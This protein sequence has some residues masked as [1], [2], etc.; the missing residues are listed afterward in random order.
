MEGKLGSIRY[1]KRG[2]KFYVYELDYYW[3]KEL[4]RS[5]QTAKYLGTATEKGGEYKKIGMTKNIISEK[6]ILDFGDSFTLKEIIKNTGLEKIIC[7]SFADLSDS[8]MNLVCYQITEGAAMY[9]CADWNEGNIASKLFPSAKIKSQDI[10]RLFNILGKQEIQQT[11]FKNYVSK[12]FPDK[13]GIL[14]DSTA[15]PSTINNSINAFGYTSN[16]IKEHITCL[17][18]VDKKSKLPIYFRALGGD[19]NDNT[20]LQ[21]TIKEIKNLGLNTESAILDAGYC[22]KENLIYMCKENIEFITRLPKSHKI[23]FE[24]IDEA[25]L[26]ESSSNAIK[27]GERMIFIKSLEKEVY[28]KKI[29]VHIILD[30]YKKAKDMNIILKNNLNNIS[31][32]EEFENIDKKLKY[33]GFFILLSKSK[34]EREEILP[35]YYTRQTIEQIFG[36]AKFN[37]N[38]LPLRV[39]TEQSVNGYLLLA[40]ISLILFIFLRKLLQPDITVNKALIRLRGLKAKIYDKEIV[41]QEPNKKIKDIVKLL[42]ILLPTSMGI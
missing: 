26:T 41:I 13:V 32:N 36:F 9:D 20:T 10:S 28:G 30:S 14:F 4:K 22:S 2:Q 5:R 38:L 1:K 34:I 31:S 18:L 21:T 33:T 29:F 39:H 23:F 6:A 3:D 17:M 15:L 12:F 16:G 27:Y 8:I 40:F 7:D 24:L 42:D 25:N 11:F 19:L 37:N 35:A